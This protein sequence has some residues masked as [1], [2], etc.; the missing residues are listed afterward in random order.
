[1]SLWFLVGCADVLICRDADVLFGLF[2][3][4]RVSFFEPKS[5]SGGR[6]ATASD[7]EKR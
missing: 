6:C 5:R 1:M 4:S 7:H 2:M 3:C